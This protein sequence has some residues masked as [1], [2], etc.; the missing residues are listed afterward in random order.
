MRAFYRAVIE[1]EPSS[2][3]GYMEFPTQLGIFALWSVDDFQQ[4]AG[5]TA[6]ITLASGS[7]MLEFE[8]DDVDAENTRLQ[9]LDDPVIDSSCRPQVLPGETPRSTS[10]TP[11]ATW[12]ISSA[13]FAD[14]PD[15]HAEPGSADGQVA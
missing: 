4:L 5:Q 3:A 9:S 11:T 14:A 15:V 12:S 10:A 1:L 6:A 7:V 2:R 13:V 8:V